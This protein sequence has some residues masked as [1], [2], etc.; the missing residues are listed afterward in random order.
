MLY[1][2]NN[3]Y[4]TL[5]YIYIQYTIYLTYNDGGNYGVYNI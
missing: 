1:N 5:I 3:N 2:E 4:N